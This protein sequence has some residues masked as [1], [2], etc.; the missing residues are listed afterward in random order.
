MGLLQIGVHILGGI[1]VPNESLYD[2]IL[3]LQ[4]LL[5]ELFHIDNFTSQILNLHL[6]QY[7]APFLIDFGHVQPAEGILALQFVLCKMKESMK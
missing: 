7:A 4:C 1:D 6:P 2:Q 5:E 3:A